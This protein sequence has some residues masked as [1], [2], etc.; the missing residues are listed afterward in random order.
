MKNF[1]KLLF[2]SVALVA[3]VGCESVETNGNNTNGGNKDDN[4][5][6]PTPNA[7]ATIIENEIVVTWE[8]VEF[9]IR[10]DLT[11]NGGEAVSADASPYSF[12]DL[13]Y[14]TEYTITVVA[15][16]ADESV[17]ANSEPKVLTVDIPA[18]EVPVYREWY[19]A[20]AALAISN[21]G[22][23]VVGGFQHNG[24]IYDLQN[25]KQEELSGYEFS[26]ISDN[27]V[28]V[29]A[30]FDTEDSGG[31]AVY[32]KDG[33][34]FEVDLGELPGNLYA[35]NLT[36]ITPDGEYAVGWYWDYANTYYTDRFGLIVPFA[37]DL[38]THKV[39]MLNEDTLYAQYRTATQTYAVDPNRAILGLEQSD[40]G[41]FGIIW[42]SD[43]ANWEYVYMEVDDI[44]QP[45]KAYGC[46]GGGYFSP[47]GRYVYSAGAE[48]K[49]N[50][51]INCAAVYDR[52]TKQMIWLESM[53][54]G[55]VSTMTEDGIAFLNDVSAG[56]GTTSF[57]IDL[58]KSLDD[59]MRIEEWLMAEHNIDI[60]DYLQD[61]I[62][63]MGTSAD[64]RTL[65]GMTNTVEY[66]WVNFV[67]CLDGVPM[68]E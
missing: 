25:N 53:K 36:G 38:V 61:G 44:R 64:G 28:A 45:V 42:E 47:N 19:S 60:E 23:W 10:Y 41:M 4:N 67:I 31:V 12:K 2:A 50:V 58:N 7:A 59:V 32:Y 17:K 30:Y 20:S 15:I 51:N 8:P 63:M 40:L 48:Y 39:I 29:G 65:L 37:Y 5:K 1:F 66:G 49:N 11:L 3:V 43:D 26:D 13:D 27:G 57:V 56:F 62:I 34:C 46:V 33:E 54:A 21:N 14:G 52:Q 55:A 24:F 35:S 16:S 22:R 6:L 9:A 68:S 18:L